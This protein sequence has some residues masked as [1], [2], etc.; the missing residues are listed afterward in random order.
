M[1]YVTYV[2]LTACK[3]KQIISH[4]QLHHNWPNNQSCTDRE[5]LGFQYKVLKILNT[6]EMIHQKNKILDNL[7]LM[8][9]ALQS[10]EILGNN[11]PTTKHNNPKDFSV[12]VR[13]F[14]H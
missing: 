5:V 9:K 1:S 12:Q 6:Q 2:T 11:N 3:C 14:V 7:T 8:T 13:Y 4:D 10:F